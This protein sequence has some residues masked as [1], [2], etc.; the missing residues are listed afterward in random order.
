M[1]YLGTTPLA[2]NFKHKPFTT[3][4]S[5]IVP[6]DVYYIF[7]DGCGA[8]TGGGGGYNG[9]G[10]GGGAGGCSGTH[11]LGLTFPVVPDETLT[12]TVPAGGAAG[13]VG[14]FGGAAG[15]A[16]IS[17]SAGSYL[18]I[19]GGYSTADPGFAVSG[20]IGKGYGTGMDS[21]AVFT[22]SMNSNSSGPYAP[23]LHGVGTE[24]LYHSGGNGGGPS[25][26]GGI[27]FSPVH[28]FVASPVNY[29]A[30]AAA[31]GTDGG[32]GHG[33]MGLWGVGGAGGAGTVA[34]G[35][36]TGYGA[37]GGGGGGNAAGGAGAPGFLRIGYISKYTVD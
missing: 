32:G 1:L 10:G 9:A 27:L 29:R 35:D 12:I 31:A 14:G 17:G 30:G 24:F 33:G 22:Q 5:F 34:G 28:G 21:V 19:P 13:T 16:I 3:S 18:L 4:G 15:G 26:A 23:V 25:T 20:G 36:A 6:A 2:G 7:V 8:G 37:G 11:V